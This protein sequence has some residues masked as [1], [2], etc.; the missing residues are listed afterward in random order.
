MG[1]EFNKEEAERVIK[2]ALLCTNASPVLRPTMSEVIDMLEGRAPVQEVVSDPA[3]YGDDLDNDV[4]FKPLRA[5]Y[6]QI[7]SNSATETKG[8]KSNLDLKS[9]D[10]S[11]SNVFSS[12]DRDLYE[13]N[14]QSL[15]IPSCDLYQI[16]LDSNTN[17]SD[18]SSLM[19]HHS[20][21]TFR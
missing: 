18:I 11:T 1:H 7:Q 6:Q 20:S 9:S 12:T 10:P 8:S 4:R 21:S 15:T 14:P 13:I 5:Y 2:V 3:I 16:S 17:T 19:S